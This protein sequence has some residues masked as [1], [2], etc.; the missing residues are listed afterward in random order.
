MVF[1]RYWE[2]IM[3]LVYCFLFAFAFS[4]SACTVYDVDT[5]SNNTLSGSLSRAVNKDRGRYVKEN[6]KYDEAP[7]YIDYSKSNPV[8]RH[9]DEFDKD[10]K[11]VKEDPFEERVDFSDYKKM[12]KKQQDKR[13]M[14]QEH[15]LS[16]KGGPV[17]LW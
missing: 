5:A 1:A 2:S 10:Q 7:I 6:K 16:E 14:E 17:S 15:G 9:D 4:L 13:N 8:L 11:I 12:K 3:K